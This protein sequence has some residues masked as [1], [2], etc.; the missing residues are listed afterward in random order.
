MVEKIKELYGLY[1]S[2]K[3]FFC[4]DDFT[5]F[6]N[7]INDDKVIY[8]PQSSDIGILLLHGYTS[9][10]YEFCSLAKFLSDKGLTVY[11]P[12]IAGHGTSP[13]DL[14]QTT[15]EQ[16]QDSVK[17]AY[18]FLEPTVKKIFIIGGSFG[19]NLAFDLATRPDVKLTGIVSLGTPIWIR[20]HRL[21]KFRLFTYGWFFKNY[22]KRSYD[23]HSIYINEQQV[24]YP[25]IPTS[26]LRRFF[27]FLKYITPNNLEEITIP[28][29]IIQAKADVVVRP[30]SA[31]YIHQH[32]KSTDKEILWIDGFNHC[33]A[34]DKK[35]ESVYQ[36]I[37]NFIY[38]HV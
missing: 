12:K 10:P 19:G 20:M 36:E 3:T 13:E 33:L 23:W 34:M 25:V 1:K 31:K 26:N 21:L 24:V 32:L 9:S 17:L 30:K 29:L 8:L 38:S 18:Q 35:C 11:A 15:I 14:A 6:Q 22:K 28:V 37:Y 4:T 16:W 5:Q 2:K 7:I 27:Y